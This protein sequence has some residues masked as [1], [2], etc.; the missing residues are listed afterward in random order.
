[1]GLGLGVFTWTLYVVAG[2]ISCVGVPLRIPESLFK[3]IPW[4][5]PSGAT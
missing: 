3:A 2:H 5:R 1:M 4:G